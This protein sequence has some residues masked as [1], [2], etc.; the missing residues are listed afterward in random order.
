VIMRRRVEQV[1]IMPIHRRQ[2][3]ARQA[4]AQNYAPEREDVFAWRE[5]EVVIG[6]P[7]RKPED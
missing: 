1:P 2:R 4:T 5:G 6:Q 3:R 7:R